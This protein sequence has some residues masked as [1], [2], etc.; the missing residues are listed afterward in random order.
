MYC[1]RT[2]IDEHGP[3]L[4]VILVFAEPAVTHGEL[5]RMLSPVM[6]THG[7]VHVFQYYTQRHK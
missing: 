5:M 1:L 6:S 7:T 3:G 2:L 4:P